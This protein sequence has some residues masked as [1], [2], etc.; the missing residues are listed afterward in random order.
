MDVWIP[1]INLEKFKLLFTYTFTFLYIAI[2]PICNR[3]EL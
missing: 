1:H 2:R 3:N